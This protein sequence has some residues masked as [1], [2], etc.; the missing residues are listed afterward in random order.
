[1]K[2]IEKNFKKY[3]FDFKQIKRVGDVAIF[4]QSKPTWP[5]VRYEVVKI[6]KHSGYYLG[7]SK[8]ESAETYPGASLWGIQGWTYI[9]LEE[10]EKRFAKACKRFNKNLQHA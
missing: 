1:M 10:A 5:D 8:L 6:G 9:D 4:Q 7:G 2:K 3:G